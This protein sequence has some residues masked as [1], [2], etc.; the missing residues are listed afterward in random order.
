M[1]MPFRMEKRIVAGWL[2]YLF[3]ILLYPLRFSFFFFFFL[4]KYGFL[5][6][7]MER[8]L[9]SN[10]YKNGDRYKFHDVSILR[11]IGCSGVREMC[12][13]A[14]LRMRGFTDLPVAGYTA[15]C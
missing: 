13:F 11:E 5:V 1:T 8:T 2:V 4:F 3:S 7:Y 12:R 15:S 14:S 9:K 10:V 6:Y